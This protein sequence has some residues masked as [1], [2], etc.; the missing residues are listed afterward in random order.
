[1]RCRSLA[2]FPIGLQK[3][4]EYVSSLGGRCS[5]GRCGG[6]GAN[7]ESPAE[8]KFRETSRLC[9]G[10]SLAASRR[11]ISEEDVEGVAESSYQ[12]C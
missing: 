7:F 8:L 4:L 1:M 11:S 5:C 9:C 6:A 3:L 12:G 2:T 10:G